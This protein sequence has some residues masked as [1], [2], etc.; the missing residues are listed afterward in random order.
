MIGPILVNPLTQLVINNNRMLAKILL[1]LH[2]QRH[3]QMKW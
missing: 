3:W 1:V 2:H